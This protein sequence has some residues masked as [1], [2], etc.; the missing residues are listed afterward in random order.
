MET[1]DSRREGDVNRK[2]MAI[3]AMTVSRVGVNIGRGA[4]SRYVGIAC[5]NHIWGGAS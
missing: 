1:G 2:A 4:R 5:V 3:D